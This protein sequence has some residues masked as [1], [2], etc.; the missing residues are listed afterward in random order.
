M[1]PSSPHRFALCLLAGFCV[2]IGIGCGETP[3]HRAVGT[4]LTSLPVASIANLS[5]GPVPLTGRVT[6]L[7]FWGT[8]CGPCRRELP[9]LA[10]MATSLENDR[11]FQ[12]VAVSVSGGGGES[13]EHLAAETGEFLLS[14]KL[15]ISAYVFTDPLAADMLSTT[16]GLQAVPATYLIGPDATVRRV[17]IGYRPQD[18]PAMAAAIV[19]LLKES[20]AQPE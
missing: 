4:K 10:R 20:P 12:L 15:P 19:A 6:L 5:A 11:R 7:N 3:R 1:I 13:P 8:W 2:L 9:G 17:W 18:E 14:Q 16:L